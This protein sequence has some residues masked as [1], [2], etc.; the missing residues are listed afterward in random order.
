M[1]N[2]NHLYYFYATARLGGVSNA[3]KFLN[4]SQPSLSTQ[5]KTFEN[6]LDRKLF[7]KNGRKMQ[8][9]AEGERVYAY[10]REIFEIADNLAEYLKSPEQ[11]DKRRIG[12]GVSDQ[13]ERPFISDLLGNILQRGREHLHSTLTVTSGSDKDLVQR[14][15]SQEIDLLLTN[16][17]V[18]GDDLNELVSLKMPVCLVIS[19][20]LLK[21]HGFKKLPGLAEV[22]K[23]DRIGLFA[24][25]EKVRL[26]HETDVF[27]QHKNLR[28][29]LLMESDIL[30]VLARAAVDGGG[31]AFLP[32]PYVYNEIQR[33][34]L[35][36]I[37]PAEGL[38][39]HRINLISR[40]Q[41]KY[42]PLF[43]ELK[44]NLS[45]RKFKTK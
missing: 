20:D 16:R 33:G 29:P 25:P 21:L 41:I 28:K 2:Y 6:V 18:A 10:C 24:P 14:L 42:D 13:I 4:V 40:K 19:K 27:M 32:V 45:A 38:W 22:F 39:R 37:G 44:A 35:I 31:C 3:A 5:I 43:D 36:A 34:L 9:T 26:R 8:L 30:S 7:E 15:R 12:I 17:P 23:N 11:K 1:F